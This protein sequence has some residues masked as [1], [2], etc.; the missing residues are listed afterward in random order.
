[1]TDFL[2]L[3]AVCI[4]NQ[5]MESITIVVSRTYKVVVVII[6][7]TAVEVGGSYPV[8]VVVDLYTEAVDCDQYLES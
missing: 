6:L 4:L 8:V 2:W 5:S 7:Y 1:M 3:S